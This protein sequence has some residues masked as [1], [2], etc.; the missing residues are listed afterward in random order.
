MGINA[1]YVFGEAWSIA[2][3]GSR[4]TAMAVALIALGLYVPGLLMLLSRNLGRLA[5]AGGEPPAVVISLEASA[6]ARDTAAKVASDPR[7]GRVR[8]ISSSDALDRFRRAYP[9]LGSALAELKEA[10]FPPT[11]EVYLKPGPSA[12][13]AGTAAQVARDAARLPGV[14]T[15]ES[16]EGFDRRFRE[17][18][19]LLRGAGLFLGGLL[20]V[21]AILSVASAIRLALDLH[22]DEIEIMRLMGATE[23][24]VRAPFWLY[25]AFEGC[26]GGAAA[27]AL[28]AATYLAATRFLLRYPHPVLSIFWA[29]FLDW[30]TSAALPLIGTAAGFLGS[31]LSL[32]R[33]AKV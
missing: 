12:A 6:D 2:R 15:A 26:A 7:V 29:D 8:I 27:L 19:R 28:L 21:A 31:V 24:A 14:E 22:R 9:S 13:A 1:R 17:A 16:E 10:P 30:R 20:T 33:K 5:T 32:G 25:G 11:L 23:G 3:S 4:Q 18:I